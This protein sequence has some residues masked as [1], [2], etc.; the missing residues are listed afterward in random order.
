[1]AA[2]AARHPTNKRIICKEDAQ[3]RIGRGTGRF[4][5]GMETAF[6]PLLVKNNKMFGFDFAAERCKLLK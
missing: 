4:A 6:S 5:E 1:M 3:R 2:K